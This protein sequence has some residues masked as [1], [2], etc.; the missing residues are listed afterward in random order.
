MNRHSFR[1]SGLVFGLL[2]L[3]AAG[4]WAVWDQD[5]LSNQQFSF[6]VSGVLIAVGVAGVISTF[7]RPTT[8]GSPT[9][10]TIDPT[11]PEEHHEQAADPQS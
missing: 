1:W 5:L 11:T 10:A 3:A 8:A 6:V 2:L 7:W 9:S 4:S